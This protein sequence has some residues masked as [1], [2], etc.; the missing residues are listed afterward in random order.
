MFDMLKAIGYL[1]AKLQ[2]NTKWFGGFSF[3]T[4]LRYEVKAVAAYKN[5]NVLF[6]FTTF[7]W[8]IFENDCY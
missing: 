4:V 6:L 8:K 3:L 5:L 2:S 1:N 7:L